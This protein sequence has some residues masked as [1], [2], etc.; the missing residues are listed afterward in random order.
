[1]YLGAHH[2]A[3]IAIPYLFYNTYTYLLDHI[4]KARMGVLAFG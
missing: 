1:M 4:D 2:F 3:K